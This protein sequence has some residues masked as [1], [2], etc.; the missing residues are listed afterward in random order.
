MIVGYEFRK[1]AFEEAKDMIRKWF[2]D[3]FE[4]ERK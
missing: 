2:A 4:D 3:V 1:T